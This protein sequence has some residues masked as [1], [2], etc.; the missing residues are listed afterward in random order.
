MVKPFRYKAFISYSHKDESWARWL[1]RS[2]ESYRIPKR[3]VAK[4]GEF[5]EIPARLKPVFRDREDLST[6]ANLTDSVKNEL[7]D[8]ESMIVICSPTA[9]QSRWVNEEIRLFRLLGR[10][11]RIYALIVDGDPKSSDPARNC[12]PL[13]LIEDKDGKA[14]EPLAADVQKGAGGRLLAKLKLVSGILGIRLDDLR[15]RDMQRRHRLWM[16]SS[17]GALIIAVVTSVLA[18]IALQARNVAETRRAHAED[19]VG[20]M[21]G[22]LRDKLGQVGRLDILDSVGDQ[23]G[24][25]LETLNPDELTDESLKQKAVVWRQLGEVSRDQGKL[26]DAMEAFTRSREVLKEL[27]SRRPDD[28]DRLY[29]WSQSEFWV[30]YV[31]WDKGE[32]D[33]ASKTFSEYMRLSEKLVEADPGNPEFVMELAYANSNL[34][35]LEMGRES[36][37]PERAVGFMKTAMEY[38]EQAVA[39]APKNNDYRAAL[40]DSHANLADAWLEVC[41]LGEA[42]KSRMRNTELAAGFLAAS[43]ADSKLKEDYANSLSGLGEMQRRVGLIDQ[44][45]TNLRGSEALFK[46]LFLMDASNVKFRQHWLERT[47]LI[48]KLLGNGGHEVEAW[49]M[50]TAIAPGLK[51]MHASDELQHFIFSVRYAKF[52]A[53]Y[54]DLAYRRGDTVLADRLLRFSIVSLEHITADHPENQYSRRELELAEFQFWSQNELSPATGFSD[55]SPGRGETQSRV[56]SCDAASLA[57]RQAVMRGDM[58]A[59]SDYTSYLLGR[60]FYEPA[61]IRFCKQY[62]T[63]DDG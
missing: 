44:S 33:E 7:A 34:G 46:E 51:E 8:A 18:I 52:Q 11:R 54:S 29:E 13:A 28:T 26:D 57:A 10:E 27:A 19:L 30:G 43:P 61:F 5:G 16:L 22:D 23:V 63:C 17:A 55:D 50:F 41:N 1:Q 9:A 31:H 59:A 20:Y 3:L 38:N 47:F 6:A 49:N 25:Y 56:Q 4:Q 58:T 36:A 37:D 62:D 14:V 48:A 21:V 32:L 12:F 35:S 53:A 2:L 40:S 60:G 15:Q 39:M 45:L 42:L 24:N